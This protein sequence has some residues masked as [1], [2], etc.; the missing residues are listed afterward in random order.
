MASIR[1]AAQDVLGDAR[2]GIGWIAVWKDGKGWMAKT[3]YPDMDRQGRLVFED[4]ELE[5]L[6]A[7]AEFDP[8][9]ILVNSYYHNLGPVEAENLTRDQLA[10]A[11][12]W[13]YDVGNAIVSEALENCA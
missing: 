1:Q 2:D 13:Q 12:R 5:S 8:N 10:Y 11:L 6:R 3:Y 4:Y 9:A 7:L